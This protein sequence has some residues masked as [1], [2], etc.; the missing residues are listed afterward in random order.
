MVKLNNS[1]K[2]EI[3]EKFKNG[4][5]TGSIMTEYKLSRSTVQRLK[6][7]IYEDNNTYASSKDQKDDQKDIDDLLNDLNDIKK[8]DI[9]KTDIQKTDIKMNERLIED[10]IIRL[11]PKPV[12][13]DS[14]FENIHGKMNIINKFDLFG[15]KQVINQFRI[16]SQFKTIQSKHRNKIS[17]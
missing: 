13:K 15:E 3:L 10:E 8:T 14:T 16:I 9:K 4:S 6:N 2:N 11:E 5:S 1:L 17:Q 12:Q 7:E